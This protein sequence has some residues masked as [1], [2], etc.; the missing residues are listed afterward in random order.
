M[1]HCNGEHDLSDTYHLTPRAIGC[2]IKVDMS[3]SLGPRKKVDGTQT[4]RLWRS[5]QCLRFY[6]NF[7][8]PESPHVESFPVTVLS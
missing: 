3:L 1:K 5:R 8:I 4:N 7:P 2:G 6:I